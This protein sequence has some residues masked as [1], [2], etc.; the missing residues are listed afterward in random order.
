MKIRVKT[1]GLKD[2]TKKVQGC[3]AGCLHN[4]YANSGYATP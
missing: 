4:F 3:R 1:D 2:T